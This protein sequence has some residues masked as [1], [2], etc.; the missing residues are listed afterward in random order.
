VPT[1]IDYEKCS[2][3]FTCVEVCPE[4]VYDENSKPVVA[5]P[6]D[7]TECEACIDDCPEGAISLCSAEE[8]AA[9]KKYWEEN[10][11]G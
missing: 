2:A 7:C 5:R 8:S 1:K 6:G 11:A 3:C 9:N 10:I 4:S